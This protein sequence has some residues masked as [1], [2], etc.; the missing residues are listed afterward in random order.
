M[1]TI[2]TIDQVTKYYKAPLT[3][4]FLALFVDMIIIF[5]LTI[6]V[7]IPF[8]AGFSVKAGSSNEV[9]NFSFYNGWY[10][11]GVFTAYFVLC[12]LF[13][14]RSIGKKIAKIRIQNLDGSKP[15]L[16]L[17]L[18]D[19]IRP[20]DLVL[21][22]LGLIFINQQRRTLG[23]LIAN[24]R[25]VKKSKKEPRK[26][27]KIFKLFG[28]LFGIFLIFFNIFMDYGILTHIGKI[29]EINRI[30]QNQW[31][32]ITTAMST[33]N[34]QSIYYNSTEEISNEITLDQFSNMISQI[35]KSLD[36]KSSTN[37]K[38]FNP[39]NWAF[40][41]KYTSVGGGVGDYEIRLTFKKVDNVWKLAGFSAH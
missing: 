3:R 13:L 37:I 26:T 1:S 38:A 34:Y 29:I 9:W 27:P 32:Q 24:T 19:L 12:D 23:D 22:T 17:I 2:Q 35:G 16:N 33:N 21:P 15:S 40:S 6:I 10:F 31:Q 20:L 14:K 7:T 36:N 39:Y 8:G 28:Y 30:A 5:I 25:V 18:R 41:S 11:F 4:R